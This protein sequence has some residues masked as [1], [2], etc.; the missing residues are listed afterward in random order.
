MIA[1]CV[2]T[3]INRTNNQE[4]CDESELDQNFITRQKNNIRNCICSNNKDTHIRGCDA[5]GPIWI[6]LLFI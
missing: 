2:N 5:F 4:K 3:Q 1:A 6:E